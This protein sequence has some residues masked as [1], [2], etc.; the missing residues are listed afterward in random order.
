MAL[1][2]GRKIRFAMA[3]F[4]LWSEEVEADVEGERVMREMEMEDEQRRNVQQGGAVASPVRQNVQPAILSPITQSPLLPAT[5]DWLPACASPITQASAPSPDGSGRAIGDLPEPAQASAGIGHLIHGTGAAASGMVPASGAHPMQAPGGL[6]P[7]AAPVEPLQEW[8]TEEAEGKQCQVFLVTFA[9]VLAARALTAGTTLRTLEDVT[10]EMVRDALL[11]AVRNPTADD[12]RR[13]GRPRSLAIQ[14][15]KMVVFLEEPRHFHVALKLSHVCRFMP[16]KLALRIRSGLASH[17]ST[18]HTMWWSALRY[19]TCATDRK[20]EIDHDPLV[21][22]L[23]GGAVQLFEESQEPFMAQVLKKRRE[24]G[25]M[26]ADPA[27]KLKGQRGAK[28]AFAKL[29]FVALVLSENL[30]TPAQVMAYVQQKGSS[31]MQS[32]VTKH[33][34]RLKEQV[35][36]A[37]EWGAAQECAKAEQESSWALVRRLAQG[38]C[39]CQGEQCEWLVKA[40]DFF[41][42]NQATIDQERLAACTAALIEK[43]PGKTRRIPFLVGPTNSGKSTIY[44]PVDAVFGESMVHHTP[45]IGS[46]MPLANLSLKDKRFLYLDEFNPVDYASLPANKPTIPINM[47]LKFLAGQWLEVQVSQSHQNGNADIR[48]KGGAAITAKAQGLWKPTDHVSAE[49][50]RHLQARVE[51]FTA[52]AQIQGQLS[53][54]T[55]CKESWCQWLLRSAEAYACRVVP[56]A[57]PDRLRSAEGPGAQIECEIRDFAQFMESA[58][59]RASVGEALSREVV[60]LGAVNVR[61]LTVADWSSLPSW[62]QLRPLEQR[63]ILRMVPR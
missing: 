43:G 45:A 59:I 62:S 42:R 55:L 23:D 47:L 48:W 50:I 26:R 31:V 58:V 34:G 24:E 13:G 6:Q 29:D 63:R 4:D 21:W 27:K 44:D 20:P 15:L 32:Y 60:A 35:A 17:W 19:G 12:R 41:L 11:D 57:P 28:V 16:F 61:E 22:T 40:N 56:S 49:D 1:P 46:S 36:H 39:A 18:S 30:K 51:V 3:D 7:C 2:R 5:Q 54:T 52:T 14:V 25:E 38:R 53:D 10:R 33:Q 9:A 37:F 8:L